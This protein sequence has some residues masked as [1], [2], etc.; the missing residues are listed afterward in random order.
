MRLFSA[1]LISLFVLSSFMNCGSSSEPE[2][3]DTT[4]SDVTTPDATTP[5]ATTPDA[6]TPDAEEDS[7]QSDATQPPDTSPGCP[8]VCDIDCQCKKGFDGCDLPECESDN[9]L[10]I[11]TQANQ[12][13]ADAANGC[14]ASS[15]CKMFEYPICGS[16]GCFQGPVNDTLDLLPLNLVAQQGVDELCSGFHCGCML[17]EGPTACFENSCISCDD[18]NVCSDCDKLTEMIV[19]DST[20]AAEGCTTDDD[21]EVA[22]V[23]HC[24]MGP[25]IACH[26]FAY[27]KAKGPG[28]VLELMNL[29]TKQENGCPWTQCDCEAS[30]VQCDQGKCIPGM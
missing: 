27:N 26:G 3:P 23:D 14:V 5:D 11:M 9:C 30:S 22:I 4:A 1:V 16:F 17:P 18:S 15:Q 13:L 12:V 7:Q 24:S 19:A 25:H 20:F 6:T 29:F 21:C 8:Y 10:Q 2:T 28:K